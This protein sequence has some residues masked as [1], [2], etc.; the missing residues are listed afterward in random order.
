MYSNSKGFS[1]THFAQGATLRFTETAEFAGG[2]G[3]GSI[4]TSEQAGERGGPTALAITL[5]LERVVTLDSA[6]AGTDPASGAD[7][8][9]RAAANVGAQQERLPY[10]GM[11]LPSERELAEAGWSVWDLLDRAEEMKEQ[12]DSNAA[13]TRAADQLRERVVRQDRDIISKMH[14][15]VAYVGAVFLMAVLSAIISLRLRDSLPLPV[16]MWSFFPALA[17]VL[18]ISTGQNMWQR[19]GDYG[20]VV[21]W[22]GVLLLAGLAVHQYRALVRI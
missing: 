21:L 9:A 20:A 18:T 1:R 15:R 22:G 3:L 16:F 13:L 8:A 12:G 14:E 7:D 10:T 2:L 17:S 4:Q 6:M 5:E 11:V 19:G